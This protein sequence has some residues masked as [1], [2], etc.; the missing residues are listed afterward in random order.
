MQEDEG[1]GSRRLVTHSMARN[2]SRSGFRV[3][4]KIVPAVADVCRPQPRHSK[5]AFF[6]RQLAAR[7]RNFGKSAMKTKNF[8][9][10]KSVGMSRV[11][12]VCLSSRM[13][14]C[15]NGA[16]FGKKELKR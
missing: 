6:R 16:A 15:Y 1:F 7:W 14:E 9:N 3:P 12:P 2:Q 11:I 13:L 10:M 4:S 5:R 8:K